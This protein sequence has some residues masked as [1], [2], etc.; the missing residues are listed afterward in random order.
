MVVEVDG[1][2][3][4]VNFPEVGEEMTLAGEGAGIERLVLTPGSTARLAST[5]E[6]VRIASEKDNVYRLD[7]GRSVPEADVWPLV[8]GDTPVERLAALRLDSVEALRNRIA[9]LQLMQL[10]E[11]GGLGSFLGGRIELFPHQLHAAQ[12][13]VESDPVRWLLADEVGLGKTVEAC[14][15]LSA[16]VRTGRAERALVVAPAT[17][18]VQWL[19]E[20]Y[21]KFHQVFV[22][23]DPDRLESVESDYGEGVNPFEVHPY[24]VL[25]LEWANQDDRLL[26]QATE[27][28]LD[29]VVV[30]EAHRFLQGENEAALSKLVGVAKHALLLTATPLQ[31][32]RRGFHRLLSLLHPEVYADFE[33]FD[34]DVSSGKA[35]ITCTSGVRRAEVG[36]LPP[37]VASPIDVGAPEADVTKDPRAAWLAKQAPAWSKRGEKCLVF[38]RGLDRLQELA[39]FLESKTRKRVSVFHEELSMAKR[40]IEVAGFRESGVPLLLCTEAGGEGRNFQFCHRMLHFDLPP[41]PVELEQRI[42]RLDRIGRELPVEI[43]YF[44]HDTSD[45][46]GPDLARLYEAL[47]LFDRPASGLEPALAPI[48]PA[49]EEAMATGQPLAVDSLVESVESERRSVLAGWSEV[50]YR[51]GYRQEMAESLL[52]QVPPDLEAKTRKFCVEAAEDLGLECVDKGGEARF[53]I[54]MGSSAV[55]E[56]LP[57]VEADARFLGTFDRAEA[58]ATDELDF[59]ANGHALVE[60]FLLELEDGRRGRAVML[61]LPK[62][63]LP[64]PGLA[65][66]VKEGAQ[67][68]VSVVS[69]DG[70]PQPSWAQPFLA[71]LPQA[72]RSKPQKRGIGDGWAR[73]VRAL[74]ERAAPKGEI[75]AVAFFFP[76]A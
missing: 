1:R 60:G 18:A 62:A 34:R 37:R 48:R 7:D 50:L 33:S 68:G 67:W 73:G 30:D 5:G 11:A 29:L 31:E 49:I 26:R 35:V 72:R 28:G 59:F 8:L 51:D 21:R 69:A 71:A 12:R 2:L 76:D 15:V 16:L 61:D 47:D 45:V 64:G 46:V 63:A 22:L 14:L 70:K 38:V 9:G 41:D 24:A 54:E 53:Y 52:S 56:T 39:T 58:V 3:L 27:A 44:R 23:L 40:D 17:L 43:L 19:G 25:P 75:I 36:G 65:C 13:A 55:I 57:G 42:G 4:R 32:D 10:R 6:S 20:L 66:L 74:A